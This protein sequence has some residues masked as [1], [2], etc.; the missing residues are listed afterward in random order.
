M[1]LCKNFVMG[2]G[3]YYFMIKF[4]FNNIIIF[5][6]LKDVVIFIFKKYQKVG[7][8]IEWFGKWDGKKFVENFMFVGLVF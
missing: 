5:R 2:K 3:K 8:E 6:K 4:V 7:K 1:K